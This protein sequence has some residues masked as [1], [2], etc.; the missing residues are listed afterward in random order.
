[1][2]QLTCVHIAIVPI[3]NSGFCCFHQCFCCFILFYCETIAQRNGRTVGTFQCQLNC[4]LNLTSLEI[5]Y[6][7][8]HQCVS[9]CFCTI[10]IFYP[11]RTFQCRIKIVAPCKFCI[12][13][14]NGFYGCT[15]VETI[16]CTQIT[17]HIVHS[18][19]RQNI[20]SYIFT[21]NNCIFAIFCM[22]QLT[23]I[24]IIFVLV[25]DCRTGCCKEFICNRYTAASAGAT[26]AT[27]AG[28]CACAGL[29]YAISHFCVFYICAAGNSNTI[30][31]CFQFF[32]LTGACDR[33]FC[34]CY[35]CFHSCIF[36]HFNF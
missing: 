5:I 16:Q 15:I 20:L 18:S 7:D 12:S 9:V 31:I 25:A 13:I 8:R 11:V 14:S 19:T 26:A 1:M 3:S 33:N 34:I 28:T 30:G 2:C 6:N 29:I 35:Y 22:C 36:C 21:H 23:C 10:R 27:T 4:I 32:N 17:R 24:G